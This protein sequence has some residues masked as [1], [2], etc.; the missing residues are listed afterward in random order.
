LT[1]TS[2]SNAISGTPED[3]GKAGHANALLDAGG[4]ALS[5]QLLQEFY[6]QSTRESRA[7]RITPSRPS[8]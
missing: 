6:V 1:R 4:V 3:Q 2:S 8:D 7:D 5:A